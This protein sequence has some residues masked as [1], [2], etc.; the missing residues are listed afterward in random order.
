MKISIGNCPELIN[1]SKKIRNEV[2]VNEQGIPIELDLDGLDDHSYHALAQI[3]TNVVG[4]ARLTISGNNK[5][6]LARVAVTKD[7]RGSGIAR[8]LIRS[9]LSYAKVLKVEIIEIHA[10]QHLKNFYESFGFDYIQ[11]VEVVG[12]HQLIEMHLNFK[13]T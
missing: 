13:N 9:I 5:A 2:F 4:T 3:G 7:H 6:V 8:H 1:N 10:H 12:E 11:D